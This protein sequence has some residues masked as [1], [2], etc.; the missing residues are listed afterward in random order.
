M[1]IV[2]NLDAAIEQHYAE[3][4]EET[5]ELQIFGKIWTL[6]KT[7]TTDVVDP[8]CKVLAATELN[9]DPA[10][11]D[12]VNPLLGIQMMSAIPLILP[13]VVC[14]E[15]RAEFERTMREKGGLPVAIIPQ[16][17][18][19]VFSA[20]DAL[21]LPSGATT[22]EPAQNAIPA[23]VS[24]IGHGNTSEVPGATSNQNFNQ[25]HPAMPPIIPRAA[26]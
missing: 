8:L 17:I 9:N 7:L 6:V 11:R 16:V 24:T 26:P 22:P 19:A 4:G 25:S 20:F 3:V 21:P 10:T 12:E 18:E 23:P 13:L 1:T 14:E 2:A 15:Q 5:R